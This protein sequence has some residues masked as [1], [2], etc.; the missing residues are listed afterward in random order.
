MIQV[1]N[2]RKVYEKTVAVDTLSFSVTAGTILGLVGP[3]GAGKTTTLRTLS[4]ILKPTEG[5]ITIAGHDIEAKPVEAKRMFALVPDVPNLFDALTVWEHL[6]F[7]ASAY[8]VEAF[9]DT[10]HR[11]LEQFELT[12]KTHTLASELSRGMKQKA[13]ICCAYL[14]DPKVIF[15]DEPL[16]G[17]D[18]KGI[19]TIKNSIRE[20]AEAGAAVIISSHFLSMIEDLCTHLLIM[21]EGKERYM[22]SVEAA[23]TEF[24]AQIQ[25][26]TLEE[27]FFRVTEGNP[28]A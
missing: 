22:G 8:K 17:L 20:R 26:A 13:A 28:T 25:D 7:I 1:E 4:G 18:P 21:H 6:Q 11:L 5:T 9:E 27:I 15:F 10:A 2:L 19:R 12:P 16:S 24:A 14:Y 3:N 23:R